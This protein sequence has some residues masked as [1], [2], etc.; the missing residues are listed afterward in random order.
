MF[1]LFTITM[2]VCQK[3]N[4]IVCH[5]SQHYCHHDYHDCYD[6]DQSERYQVSGK[7]IG[8]VFRQNLLTIATMGGV[9]AG[10]Y[11]LIKVVIAV[12]EIFLKSNHKIA[13]M[14]GVVAGLLVDIAVSFKYHISCLSRIL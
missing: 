3:L 4:H 6:D 12:L 11:F 1:E 13:T 9:V 5:Q 14:G 2:K 8:R 7:A 10:L